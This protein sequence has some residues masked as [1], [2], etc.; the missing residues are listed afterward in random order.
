MATTKTKKSNQADSTPSFGARTA[1]RV[2][3][4]SAWQQYNAE[5][6]FNPKSMVKSLEELSKL[7]FPLDAFNSNAYQEAIAKSLTETI[8][9]EV[10]V[11]DF[12]TAMGKAGCKTLR[13]I[14]GHLNFFSGKAA[15]MDI[16]S[17]T[18]PIV[19]EAHS[20]YY[21]ERL[22]ER[23]ERILQARMQLQNLIKEI[24]KR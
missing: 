8:S 2:A 13:I 18:Q 23:E 21:K 5:A 6:K 17:Y 14:D 19:F 11:K 12:W 15:K 1:A 7:A 9:P 16:T 20:S 10:G 3:Q 22:L 24:H 4:E